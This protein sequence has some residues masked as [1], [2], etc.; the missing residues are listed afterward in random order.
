MPK[1][2]KAQGKEER[3]ALPL[4]LLFLCVARIFPRV[5]SSTVTKEKARAMHGPYLIESLLFRS[6]NLSLAV[7]R[8]SIGCFLNEG[9]RVYRRA[10]DADFIVKVRARRTAG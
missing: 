3:Q 7:A 10:G 8:I 5:L 2:K 9:Q 1:K 6:A 4:A